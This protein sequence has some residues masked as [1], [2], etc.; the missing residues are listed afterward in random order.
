MAS[1]SETA[2][3]TFVLRFWREWSG[4]A[5][6][7]RGRIEH[8]QSGQRRDFLC[9]DEMLRF[10]QQGGVIMERRAAAPDHPAEVRSHEDQTHRGD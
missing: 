3:T 5:M 9:L 2:T 8:V 1:P 10:L 7:W 6:R 4:D